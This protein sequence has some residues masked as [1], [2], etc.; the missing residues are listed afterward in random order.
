MRA[1]ELWRGAV[2]MGLSALAVSSAYVSPATQASSAWHPAS[3][4]RP[5][6]GATTINGSLGAAMPAAAI[7][8]TDGLPAVLVSGRS[9]GL[10]VHVGVA[11]GQPTTEAHVLLAGADRSV[12]VT[13]R[14]LRSGA[15]STL[16]CT[17]LTVGTGP[18]G[19]QVRVLVEAAHG[20]RVVATFHHVVV[21]TASPE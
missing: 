7:S 14:L 21:R 18:S 3:A 19:V 17:F 11:A 13:K 2:A 9:Y 1:F 8:A 10:T 5:P 16:H 6:V 20:G 12:C 15:I 4:Q